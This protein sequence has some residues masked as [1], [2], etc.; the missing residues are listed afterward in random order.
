MLSIEFVFAIAIVKSF[1]IEF[2][3]L[4]QVCSKL[5]FFSLLACGRKQSSNNCRSWQ[6]RRKSHS[7]ALCF[8]IIFYYHSQMNEKVLFSNSNFSH[9]NFC[10]FHWMNIKLYTGRVLGTRVIH[11]TMLFY[12]FFFGFSYISRQYLWR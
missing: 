11:R 2:N 4:W 10:Q 1:S 6:N 8:K 9:I 12:R 7:L 5:S 3:E